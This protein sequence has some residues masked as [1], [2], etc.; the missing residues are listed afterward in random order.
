MKKLF[1]S[2]TLGVGLLGFASNSAAEPVEYVKV[3]DLFA[4]GYYYVPGS[5]WCFNPV[6]G[7]ARQ[8]VEVITIAGVPAV[9]TAPTAIWRTRFPYPQGKWVMDPQDACQQGRLVAIGAFHAGDFTVD[10]FQ[11]LRSP[12]FTLQLNSSEMVTQVIMSGGFY[13]PR[14]PPVRS[15]VSFSPSG[16]CLR[17]I[18]P[19][20]LETQP[21][22][23]P[24]NP[25]YGDGGLP[26]GCIGMGKTLN[27]PAA[28]AIPATAAYPNIDTYFINGNNKTPIAG[29]YVY[30]KQ[31]V[32]TTDLGKGDNLAT[33]SYCDPILGSDDNP[34]PTSCVAPTGGFY[35]STTHTFT[36]FLPGQHSLAGTL[37]VWACVEPGSD[38]DSRNDSRR[39]GGRP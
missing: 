37:N 19:A 14:Q 8:I 13:D 29:P 33:L 2:L 20:V 18:D 5:D 15:G 6:Q 12:P 38:P 4:P 10:T 21:S 28:Y 26:I 3:C 36:P 30:G 24:L 39:Q 7:E 35:D 25:P 17:S 32:V 22:G 34:L 9:T 16:W 11:K 31:L 1:L 27:M 23:S